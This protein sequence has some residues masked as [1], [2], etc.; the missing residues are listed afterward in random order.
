MLLLLL[1]KKKKLKITVGPPA[2]FAR[3]EFGETKLMLSSIMFVLVIIE[4]IR[5]YSYGVRVASVCELSC[6]ES[7]RCFDVHRSKV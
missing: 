3:V 7:I 4:K 5:N 6:V 2:E 1:H